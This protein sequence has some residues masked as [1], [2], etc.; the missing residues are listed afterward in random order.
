V[1]TLNLNAST[2]GSSIYE[3]IQTYCRLYFPMHDTRGFGLRDNFGGCFY[4]LY[5]EEVFLDA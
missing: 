5:F 3:I 2:A 4:I 1:A